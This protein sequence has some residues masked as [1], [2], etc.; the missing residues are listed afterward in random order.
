ML[1]IKSNPLQRCALSCVI[2]LYSRPSDGHPRRNQKSFAEEVR[3]C[4]ILEH[5]Q[6]SAGK[7]Q[8]N[9]YIKHKIPL[10]YFILKVLIK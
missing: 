2:L 7:D 3:S 1:C 8:Q 9:N 6:R 10:H 5:E 4:S